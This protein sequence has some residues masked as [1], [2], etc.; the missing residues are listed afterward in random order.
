MTE[1]GILKSI[2]TKLDAMVRL[3]ASSVIEGKTKS[4]VHIKNIV[5]GKEIDPID[6]ESEASEIKIENK[7]EVK[8]NKAEVLREIE[9]DSEK[10]I[11]SYEVDLESLEC[12]VE[13]CN[14]EIV[15]EIDTNE[16]ETEYEQPSKNLNFIEKLYLDFVENLRSFFQNIFHKI[17]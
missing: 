17:T 13:I 11:E 14:T 5:N 3:L 4:E 9:I 6:I 2:D 1:E 15:P 7:I 12:D 8:D 16:E 10:S